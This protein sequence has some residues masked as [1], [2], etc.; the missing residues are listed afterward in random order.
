MSVKWPSSFARVS[1][2]AKRSGLTGVVRT[3][4]DGASATGRGCS[5]RSLTRVV[6]PPAKTEYDHRPCDPS[7]DCTMPSSPVAVITSAP[8]ENLGVGHRLRRLPQV[9]HPPQRRRPGPDRPEASRASTIV[10]AMGAEPTATSIAA[11]GSTP[12]NQ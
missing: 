11:E 3:H 7:R 9:L 12:E 5:E 1:V 8:R 10:P 4:A 2:A 6:T